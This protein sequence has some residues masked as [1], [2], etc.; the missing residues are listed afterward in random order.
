MF[1][2]FQSPIISIETL[3]DLFDGAAMIEARP[4][5]RGGTS[6]IIFLAR[7][8][9]VLFGHGDEWAKVAVAGATRAVLDAAEEARRH[10]A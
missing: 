2:T 10:A 1:A 9:R 7:A 6:L 8:S 3:E 4:G 5:P